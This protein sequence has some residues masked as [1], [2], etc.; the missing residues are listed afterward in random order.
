M[1]ENSPGTRSHQH[2]IEI[3]S[4]VR[5]VWSALTD[6]KILTRWYVDEAEVEPREGG[7]YWVSW[8]AEGEG[9]ARIDVWEPDRRLRLAHLPFKG[10]PPI[11]EGGA[12]I[13]DFTLEERGETTVLR[14]V[15][16]GIPSAPEWDGFFKG[17]DSG[18]EDYF[19]FLRDM[20][21]IGEEEEGEEEERPEPEPDRRSPGAG[22]RGRGEKP[23]D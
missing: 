1:A 6:P 14:L 13:E 12:V 5:T 19:K 23:T 9:E 11:P 15:Y 18:W 10:S 16:S 22:R 2:E 21:E 17:T 3:C 4:P 20:L 8:G 7:R